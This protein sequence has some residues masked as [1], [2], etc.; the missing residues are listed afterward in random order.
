MIV[1][2]EHTPTWLGKMQ[3][4]TTA[5]LLTIT[6]SRLVSKIGKNL[7]RRWKAWEIREILNIKIPLSKLCLQWLYLCLWCHQFMCSFYGNLGTFLWWT[8]ELALQFEMETLFGMCTTLLL[9]NVNPTGWFE[10]LPPKL[11]DFWNPLHKKYFWLIFKERE[12][13]LA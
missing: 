6:E 1:R 8:W 5:P 9:I 7:K 11:K 2:S 12:T 13:V 10:N 3:T 4:Q